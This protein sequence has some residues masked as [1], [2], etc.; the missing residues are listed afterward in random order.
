MRATYLYIHVCTTAQNQILVL[1]DIQAHVVIHNSDPAFLWPKRRHHLHRP[2]V[3]IIVKS[4]HRTR[5]A[6][7]LPELAT[8]ARVSEPIA[9]AR[10][11]RITR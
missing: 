7:P 2:I 6:L 1:E 5:E 4:M 3:W 8:T 10:F 11:E 9:A